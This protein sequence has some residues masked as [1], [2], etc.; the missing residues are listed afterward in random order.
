MTGRDLISVRPREAVRNQMSG[1]VLRE[2]DEMWQDELFAPSPDPDPEVPGQGERVAPFQ[3]YL[4]VVNWTDPSHVAR[5]LRVFEVALH[6]LWEH[7]WSPTWDATPI[8]ERLRRLFER[9][10]YTLTEAGK[11]AGASVTVIAA[12]SLAGLTDPGAI[13]DHLDRI[14]R[15]VEHDDPAQAIGSAKELI[16]STAKLILAERNEPFTDKDDLPNL[17]RRAQMA[18]KVHPTNAPSGAGPDGSDGITKIL[19]A[20]TT[21]TA[22]LLNSA[23]VGTAPATALALPA[24]VLVLDMRI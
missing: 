14:A 4:N 21:V 1:T 6:P 19:G 24:L 20:V 17:T 12:E 9:D 7:P 22:G 2:I 16:E 5:A 11:I 23:T 15:A 3:A 18:L 8:I 10:G 13:L